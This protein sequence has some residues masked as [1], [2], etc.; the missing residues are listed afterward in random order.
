LTLHGHDKSKDSSNQ[1]NFLKLLQF[2]A[3]H[4]EEI[5]KIVVD[6]AHKNHQMVAPH[7]QRDIANVAA[8]E[9]L[10]VILKDLGDSF[11]AIFV[12]ES[13]DISIKK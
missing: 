4:N 6:I 1:G 3:K 10:N 12:D 9:T 11:F 5:D 7:I 2:F 13:R 8:S